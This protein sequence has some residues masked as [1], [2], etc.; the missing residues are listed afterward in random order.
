MLAPDYYVLDNKGWTDKDH[1]C[2]YGGELNGQPQMVHLGEAVQFKTEEDAQTV[3][4]LYPTIA[5]VIVPVS[6]TVPITL[7]K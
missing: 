6:N 3:A 1:E 4:S 5:F 2:Y 7:A